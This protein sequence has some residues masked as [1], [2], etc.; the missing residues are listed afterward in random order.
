[1]KRINKLFFYLLTV[2]FILTAFSLPALA[3]QKKTITVLPFSNVSE[4]NDDVINGQ[5]MAAFLSGE[6]AKNK[7]Y[8]IV[9][10][11]GD[12]KDVL[13]EQALGATGVI[14]PKTAAK[15]GN[16]TG[17]QYIVKGRIIQA[18][19]DNSG[20]G[21]GGLFGIS[22]Q[23]CTVVLSLIF[24]DTTTGE[25]IPIDNVEGKAE[26]SSFAANL[27]DMGGVAFGQNK[28]SI[29]KEA[30]FKAIKEAAERINEINPLEGYIVN[31]E[32]KRIYIDLGRS[33]GVDRGQKFKI[34]REGEVIRHPVTGKVIGT[35]KSEFGTIT[36]TEVDEGMAIGEAEEGTI[37]SILK[38]GDKVRRIRQ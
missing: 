20:G 21:L 18:T 33:A 22:S 17:A 25:V 35:K 31:I 3:A 14:N 19:K 38:P 2:F 13:D 30:A 5:A 32:G 11:K 16:V 4:V 29:F 1:M 6:L 27:P 37:T 24:L 26:Q 9:G 15:M 7:T 10:R 28:Q 12:L 36:I 23:E 34:F 8:Q